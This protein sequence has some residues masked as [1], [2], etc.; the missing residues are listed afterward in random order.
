MKGWW[1][2]IL[3]VSVFINVSGQQKPSAGPKRQYSKG[4]GSISHHRKASQTVTYLQ[5]MVDAAKRNNQHGFAIYYELLLGDQYEKMDEYGIA[6]GVFFTA[7]E[8]SKK[9]RP[10]K[11]TFT[12]DYLAT[13]AQQKTYFD[14]IDRLGY[15]YLSIGNLK[16][17]EQL[18]QESRAQRNIFFPK[19]SIH[20]VHPEVGMGSYYFRKGQYEKTYEQFSKAQ[21]MMARAT[22]TGYDFDNVN[23]LFLNDLVELCLILGKQKEAFKYLN[24]LAIASSGF[25]KF[26]S[27]ISS[28]M[29]IARVFELKS[30][31]YLTSGDFKKAREYLEKANHYNPTS[32]AG[33]SVK[34]K[35][36]R[37]EA[38]LNWYEAP[39]EKVNFD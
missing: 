20:R 6:E 18:F 19:Y 39:A 31:C 34:L 11:H 9:Y 37:T 4:I 3:I 1:L 23:R 5:Q 15:F 22:T 36:L 28:N 38:I 27:T 25:G 10:V 24:R 26:G 21:K 16:N 35:L 30:R 7:Y 33:S 29:E 13:A 32:V 17:A 8:E 14:P 2:T 12:R